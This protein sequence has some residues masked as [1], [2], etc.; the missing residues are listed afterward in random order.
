MSD[1]EG[2]RRPAS[3]FLA[4]AST[5]DVPSLPCGARPP[6]GRL[7]LPHP[8]TER[9][10]ERGAGL[11]GLL[12]AVVVLGGLAV[13]AVVSVQAMTASP[14]GLK[15][16]S[17][18]LLPGAAGPTPAPPS[19]PAPAAGNNI[20][21]VSAQETC[22][23][24]FAAAQAAV[25]LYQAEHGELPVKIGQVQ[26]VVRDPLSTDR[27]TITIDPLHAGGLEVATPGH[28]AKDGDSNCD[29]AA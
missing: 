29:F 15:G 19:A 26:T 2:G 12:V 4:C 9:R 7:L 6:A 28:P 14:T 8:S 13:A 3:P 24:N 18:A 10:V 16:Q 11:I 20:L 22:R 27:F 21:S 1:Q 5:A 17:S 25:S 23:A